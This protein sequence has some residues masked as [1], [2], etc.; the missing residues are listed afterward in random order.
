MWGEACGPR[1]AAGRAPG[2]RF[3]DLHPLRS[4]DK[5]GHRPQATGHEP[6]PDRQAS[7]SSPRGT[8]P[9]GRTAPP[10]PATPGGPTGWGIGPAARPAASAPLGSPQSQAAPATAEMARPS[11]SSLNH[12]YKPPAATQGSGWPS[13]SR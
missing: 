9:L 11:P 8:R 7:P 1:G 10:R 2:V 4:T 12:G 3:P 13:L 6:L 5:D